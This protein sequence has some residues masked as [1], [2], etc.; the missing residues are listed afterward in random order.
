MIYLDNAATTW[1]KPEEV[2]K[3]VDDCLRGIGGNPGRGGH[4]S[5][6]TATYIL[7]EAR[8]ALAELFQIKQP[9]NIVFAFNATDA[10]NMAILGS[11]RQG[12]HVVT[13]SMEHNAVARPLRWL[14]SNGVQLTVVSSDEQGRPDLT[15]LGQIIKKGVTAVVMSHASNVTGTVMPID[16][17]GE[18]TAQYGGLFIVDA[19]QTAGVENIDVDKMNIDMLAFSGHKGL[20]GPQGTGGLYIRE[21]ISL[22]PLRYGG[23]GSQSEYDVQPD[24]LPDR[25]ESGTPNTPG[26][27]G[28]LAGVRFI[29]ATGREKIRSKE[30]VLAQKLLKGLTGMGGVRVYG[31]SDHERTAVVS[32]NIIGVD[33]GEIAHILDSEFSIACRAGLHCAPWAHNTIGTLKTGTIR[34]SPGFFNTENEIEQALGAVQMIVGR[35][36]WN[37]RDNS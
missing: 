37:E 6:R 20:F 21:G 33:S 19:A 4:S 34:L 10:L 15:A 22:N 11:L 32:F 12:D 35:R 5:A 7:Y 36:K 30:M 9:T 1:P 14:E 8:E 26:I 3:A 13:T 16:C 23:T 27:A 18:L 28:L 24:F 2:Y 25:L 29:L 17:I 31:L